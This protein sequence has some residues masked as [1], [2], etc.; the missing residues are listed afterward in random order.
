MQAYTAPELALR[1]TDAKPTS[2]NFRIDFLRI[3]AMV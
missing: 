3:E 1:I 2:K